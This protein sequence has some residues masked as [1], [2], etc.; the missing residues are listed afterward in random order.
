MSPKVFVSYSH[1][2]D[3]HKARVRDV[4]ARLRG[5]GLVVVFDQD[6]AG[7][8]GPAEGWPRWCERQI[9]ECDYVL[10]CCTAMFHERF[11]GEAE[12][13]TGRGVAWEALSIRQYL[14]ANANANRK[15]RALIL[16][17]SDRAHVPNVLQNYSVF[18]TTPQD[19][20]EELRGWLGVN[21]P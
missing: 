6:M 16:E 19:I 21:T 2:S 3:A 12:E 17:E 4:V 18:L 11:E 13:N 9:V 7:V 5:Q 10:A 8:G 1:D 15:V 20:C 14:Y